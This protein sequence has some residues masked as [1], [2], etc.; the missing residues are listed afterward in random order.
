M[1]VFMQLIKSCYS[2]KDI[3]LTRFQ[4]IGKTI[5]FVFLL[6]LV[7]IIPSIYFLSTSMT[8][9]VK[10]AKDTVQKELPEFSIEDGQLVSNA[11]K[12][13]TVTKDEL[14]MVF[15]SSGEA[16]ANDLKNIDFGIGLLKD[17]FVIVQGE[18]TQSYPYSMLESFNLN[19]GEVLDLIEKV[20]ASLFIILPLMVLMNYVFASGVKF[21]EISILAILG[22]LIKN[23][24][25]RRLNYGQLWRMSAYS[26]TL[27]TLFFT[28]MNGLHTTVPGGFL[29][30]WLVAY[31]VLFLAV[32][33]IPQSK[34][35]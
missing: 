18:N 16:K 21:I 31:M 20:E 19:K 22:L 17:E 26:V 12:P 15:D 13:I 33:E 35:A 30:N 29:L 24:T 5:L 11:D 28:I 7:S 27:P 10:V 25:Q 32:K 4:G 14:V 3:A 6:T 34:N 8:E 2:P 9:A 23:I 1:N